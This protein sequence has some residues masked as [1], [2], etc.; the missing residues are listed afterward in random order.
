MFINTPSVDRLNDVCAKINDVTNVL[1]VVG[2]REQHING[3]NLRSV[4][5][6]Y[7]HL[8]SIKDNKWLF[9]ET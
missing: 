8:V 2:N 3:Y 4:I 6:F 7:L 5:Y 9:L 1:S